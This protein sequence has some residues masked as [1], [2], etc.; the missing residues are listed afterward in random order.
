MGSKDYA[1][2]WLNLSAPD[3]DQILALAHHIKDRLPEPLREQTQT[4]SL[5]VAEFP[6]EDLGDDL[7]LETPFDL[8]GLFEGRGKAE[9]WTPRG[10]TDQPTLTLFRR[11]ILD[12]WADGDEP[13]GEIILHI[14]ANELGHHFGLKED[15]IAAITD[16][17]S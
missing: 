16:A 8:L 10:A 17:V 2:P 9:Y 4:V 11:A 6:S 5:H 13:L 1:S 14:I 3:A 12:H 15:E 7:A